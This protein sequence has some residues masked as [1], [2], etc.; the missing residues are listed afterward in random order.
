M[1]TKHILIAVAVVIFIILIG[2]LAWY[3]RGSPEEDKEDKEEKKKDEIDKLI[4]EINGA[5]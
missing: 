4:S 3:F 1:E 5:D 2:A